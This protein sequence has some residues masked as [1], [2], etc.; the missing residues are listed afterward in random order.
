MRTAKR[1]ALVVAGYVLA[2]VGGT[3]A[4]AVNDYLIPAD[5]QSSSGGMVAFG[6]MIVFVLATGVLGLIP[7]W[8]LLKL[9]FERWPRQALI[10]ELVVAAAGPVSWLTVILL[11]G[12]P[13]PQNW[14]S[15]GFE[16][17]GPVVAFI[18]LPRMVFGPVVLVVEAV[19]LF[20]VR[21][22]V[23]KR[24]VVAAMLMD[25]VPLSLYALRLARVT[26]LSA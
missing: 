13:H 22:P 21:G 3:V 2:V 23:A 20:L 16:W 1:L 17:L 10:V 4:V 8:F 24:L 15:I 25:F 7:T 12:S 6:D 18:A 19:T 26:L 11:A 9:A 5:I 14:A